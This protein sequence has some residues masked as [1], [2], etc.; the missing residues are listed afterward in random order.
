MP[1]IK[2]FII[3]SRPSVN[4]GL[5]LLLDAEADFC[6]VGEARDCMTALQAAPALAPHVVLVDIDDGY[7][8]RDVTAAALRQI[9]DWARVVLLTFLD[10]QQTS[11][12]ARQVRAGDVVIKSS[13]AHTLLDALRSVS[14]THTA[15][16]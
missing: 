9:S 14:V 5:H 2:L 13:P 4:K 12:L 10:N 11:E 16:N 6:I 15:G 8:D 3:E 1:V 7:A